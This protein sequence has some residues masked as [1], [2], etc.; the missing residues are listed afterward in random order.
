[1]RSMM[2]VW[3]DD[4]DDDDDY[5][6]DD[7]DDDDDDADASCC[8]LLL[9]LNANIYVRTRNTLCIMN[10]RSHLKARMM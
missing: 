6:D 9:T 8:A 1:M 5:E 10:M 3:D 4:D 2:D 7:D